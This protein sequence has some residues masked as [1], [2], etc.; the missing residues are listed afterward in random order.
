[1]VHHLA[2]K[3]G[4]LNCFSHR[5]LATSLLLATTVLAMPLSAAPLM[6]KNQYADYSVA[7]QCAEM[8]FHDDLDKKESELIRIEDQYGL[9]DE[10]FD[11]F[12]E[13]VTEYE[14]DDSLLDN[15]RDRVTAECTS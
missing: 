12:D 13:L 3:L 10:T 1:M 8:K 9:S 15:I 2:F 11:E 5:P 4:Q 14:R 6:T 7:F